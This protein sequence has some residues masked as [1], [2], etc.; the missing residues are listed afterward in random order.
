MRSEIPS[1]E[2]LAL[3]DALTPFSALL[4][5]R[6]IIG[7]IKSTLPEEPVQNSVQVILS[8]ICTTVT[9]VIVYNMIEWIEL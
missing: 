9:R 3:A 8:D 6:F 5:G 2:H 4:F 1:R 7:V